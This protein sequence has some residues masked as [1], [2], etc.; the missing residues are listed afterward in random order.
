MFVESSAVWDS[1]GVTSSGVN[2][3]PGL[4]HDGQMNPTS[5]REEPE[6]AASDPIRVLAVDDEQGRVKV[7]P[8]ALEEAPGI[9]YLG[10][11]THPEALAGPNDEWSW[12]DYDV[13]LLD[14]G[15]MPNI[16]DGSSDMVKNPRRV[17]DV[18]MFAGFKVAARI[19]ELHPTGPRPFIALITTYFRDPGVRERAARLKVVDGFFERSVYERDDGELLR[20]LVYAAA[21]GEVWS[22]GSG[23]IPPPT[24]DEQ[25]ELEQLLEGRTV[26]AGDKTDVLK[27]VQAGVDRMALLGVSMEDYLQVP[28]DWSAADRRRLIDPVTKA[29]AEHFD[30]KRR[31]DGSVGGYKIERRTVCKLFRRYYW[32]DRV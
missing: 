9:E 30:V 21:E 5:T 20:R 1:G 28:R 17:D 27:A 29:V 22:E 10:W 8:A 23:E 11:V 19:H 2:F 12:L 15:V 14:L 6:R 24:F 13:V 18:D 25:R 26:V 7:Y 32:P 16:S 4:A 31:D 3:H